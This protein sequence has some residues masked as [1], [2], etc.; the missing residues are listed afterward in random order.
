MTPEQ[1]QRLLKSQKQAI[2]HAISCV[3]LSNL[4]IDILI[5]NMIAKRAL[6]IQL[7]IAFKFVH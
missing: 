7:C 2:A 5:N 4:Y 6:S 1:F 3:L